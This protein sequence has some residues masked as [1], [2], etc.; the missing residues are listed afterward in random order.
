MEDE[1]TCNT[2]FEHYQKKI[3]N[4][5]S[6]C[7]GQYPRRHKKIETR[8]IQGGQVVLRDRISNSSIT[9]SPIAAMAWEF[10]DG[11]NTID[12]IVESVGELIGNPE[13]LHSK[14]KQLLNQLAE[15]GF[16]IFE[17]DPSKK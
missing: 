2:K 13:G 1:D 5:D 16:L 6:S 9:L 4:R 11:L 8:T 7:Q 12:D 15:A 14:I 10:C 3:D 17:P